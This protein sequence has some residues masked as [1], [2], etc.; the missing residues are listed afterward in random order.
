MRTTYLRSNVLF[1]LLAFQLIVPLHG[2][3]A[4]PAGKPA[5]TAKEQVLISLP[6][7]LIQTD[8]YGDSYFQL[9]EKNQNHTLLLHV[10]EN[11]HT[12]YPQIYINGKLQGKI[13]GASIANFTKNNNKIVYMTS[14]ES[15]Q[16]VTGLPLFKKP[17][18]LLSEQRLKIVTSED[19]VKEY[20]KAI[21]TYWKNKNLSGKRLERQVAES[22][23]EIP[24]L[25]ENEKK[26]LMEKIKNPALNLADFIKTY[27]AYSSE[28][29]IIGLRQNNQPGE[30]LVIASSSP[31]TQEIFLFKNGS[32]VAHHNIP[33]YFGIVENKD[34]TKFAYRGRSP[35]WHFE[36][37]VSVIDDGKAG[38]EYAWTSQ[39]K[40]NSK[41]ELMYLATVTAPL[42]LGEKTKITCKAVVGAT[43]T[44]IECNDQLFFFLTNQST[45][46][47]FPVTSP[48]GKTVVYPELVKAGKYTDDNY[49]EGIIMPF[50]SRLVI[51]GK[52]GKTHP[53]IDTPFFTAKG[54]ATLSYT[55]DGDQYVEWDGKKSAMY[56]SLNTSLI[57]EFD[58]QG[59]TSFYA[60][61]ISRIRGDL[62]VDAI[63][64]E[65]VVSP[66]S[67]SIAFAGYEPGKGWTVL[68]N[69]KDI[70][71]YDYAHQ[72]T[73]S[74]D[75]KDLAYV[76]V[77]GK[78]FGTPRTSALRV[79][80]KTIASHEN[81][82]HLQYSADGVLSY[83]AKDKN[84]IA[85]YSN[86]KK[87]SGDFDRILMSPRFKGTTVEF[88]GARKNKVILVTLP[89]S[90][91]KIVLK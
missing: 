22:F 51:N 78:G 50:E 42:N 45:Y 38:K 60:A 19:Y 79:N 17:K 28:T 8:P 63:E 73:F 59:V 23:K 66:D 83:I 36:S 86:G 31:F 16:K 34:K 15:G 48:D 55:S 25:I 40:Y 65:V 57:S 49:E 10:S 7:P 21:R 64:Q 67:N 18:D 74:P 76:A 43:E 41:N 37:K 35:A 30:I 32:M 11:D 70:G 6:A 53:F 90:T 5:T 52:P 77:T 44:D 3:A 56:Q 9:D 87:L 33:H 13:K 46:F 62:G 26:E 27:D 85:L 58:Y 91:V 1:L 89:L 84:S 82:S 47:D 29:R 68:R 71:T 39:P 72:L 14:T 88:V 2:Y 80:D 4:V 20:E 61:M 75:S 69:M 12:S 24:A 81:I 54:L